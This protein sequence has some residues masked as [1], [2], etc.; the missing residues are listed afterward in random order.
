MERALSTTVELTS[1]IFYSSI[2]TKKGKGEL[3][4]TLE[5]N[6]LIPF[7]ESTPTTY[8]SKHNRSPN[9]E[10]IANTMQIPTIDKELGGYFE[11]SKT[12]LGDNIGE[13]KKKIMHPTQ[14]L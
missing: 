4:H 13:I 7:I 12:H 14:K 2:H 5:T 1:P 8:T 10:S 6:D 11:E 9:L 3:I